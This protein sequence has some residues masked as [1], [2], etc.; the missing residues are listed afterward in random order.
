[1]KSFWPIRLNCALDKIKNDLK[2]MLTPLVTY[3]TCYKD[4]K[5]QQKHTLLL[6]PPSRCISK[7]YHRKTHLKTWRANIYFDEY[8]L[9][10]KKLNVKFSPKYKISNSGI[11]VNVKFNRRDFFIPTKP[12]QEGKD[13]M[14]ILDKEIIV[15]NNSSQTE[16]IR[17]SAI[18]K[19]LTD[20]LYV[21]WKIQKAV[22]S[23]YRKGALFYIQS[24]RV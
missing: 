9:V 14:I 20:A 10:S 23:F 7:W 21:K 19:W 1:M 5:K 11:P 8:L 4:Y 24:A 12:A 22:D 15:I 17:M 6:W 18:E 2:G 3:I 16:P 13:F